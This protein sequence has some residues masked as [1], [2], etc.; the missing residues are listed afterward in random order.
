MLRSAGEERKNCVFAEYMLSR[1]NMGRAGGAGTN[2]SLS[3]RN[4]YENRTCWSLQ[5]VELWRLL[6]LIAA[7]VF[8]VILLL[9]YYTIPWRH[10]RGDWFEL[11]PI[12]KSRQLLMHYMS[13]FCLVPSAHVTFFTVSVFSVLRF[14]LLR[15]IHASIWYDWN[16]LYDFY[17]KLTKW[18]Q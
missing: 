12:G 7:N 17:T 5:K 8:T 9:H 1:T 15:L 18:L 11:N 16:P 2:V 4:D 14:L 3:T 13:W 6:L 10:H